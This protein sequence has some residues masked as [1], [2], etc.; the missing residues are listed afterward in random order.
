MNTYHILVSIVF[1]IVIGKKIK[2]VGIVLIN[3]KLETVDQLVNSICGQILLISSIIE[4]HKISLFQSV[5]K[6]FFFTTWFEHPMMSSVELHLNHH[7]ANC[8]SSL[9]SFTNFLDLHSC[10]MALF[11][12]IIRWDFL[13]PKLS[14]ILCYYLN[15][16]NHSLHNSSH[17]LTHYCSSLNN[18]I[19]T[20]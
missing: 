17:R 3:N 6:P 12:A 8:P 13:L 5:T 10:K 20:S 18:T 14:F 11:L 15:F 9:F 2:T 16:R 1:L 7:R 4:I 19:V